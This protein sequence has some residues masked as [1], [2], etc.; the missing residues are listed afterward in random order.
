[1]R[2]KL[3]IILSLIILQATPKFLNGQKL[4]DGAKKLQCDAVVDACRYAWNGY[5]Q[6]A[7]GYDALKPISKTGQNWYTSS[8]L[9]TPVDAF[10]TF[11]LLKMKTEANE[12]KKMICRRPELQ[13]GY[14]RSAL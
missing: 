11:T 7:G 13:Q 9:M 10:D 4:S 1:M 3:F 2:T 6:Y 5:K 8:L 12:A 14:E